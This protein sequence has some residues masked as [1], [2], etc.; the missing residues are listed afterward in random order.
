MVKSYS[1]WNLGNQGVDTDYGNKIRFNTRQ[2]VFLTHPE[3]P[4]KGKFPKRCAMRAWLEWSH[5]SQDP[6]FEKNSSG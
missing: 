1:E 5:D 3:G 2:L 4:E 6:F